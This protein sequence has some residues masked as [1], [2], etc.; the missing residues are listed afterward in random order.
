MDEFA[1]KIR[2]IASDA[3]LRFYHRE[4]TPGMD[5]VVELIAFLV[6]EPVF[7]MESPSSL[8]ITT[9]EWMSWNRLVLESPGEMSKAITAFLE[10][11]RAVLPMGPE[12][13]KTWA[14]HLMRS[15]LD[16]A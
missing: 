5:P 3:L 11:E 7:S 9:E 16:R 4:P 1:S 12:A 6:E 10:E 14:V 13:M 8:G 15:I 2:A